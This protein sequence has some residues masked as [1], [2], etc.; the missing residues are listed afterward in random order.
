MK[1]GLAAYFHN[2]LIGFPVSRYQ[3]FGAGAPL[4]WKSRIFWLDAENAFLPFREQV[5]FQLKYKISVGSLRK[6]DL[7]IIITFN[8]C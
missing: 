7:L 6:E 5:S 2:Q 8:S 1:C 4:I 3:L